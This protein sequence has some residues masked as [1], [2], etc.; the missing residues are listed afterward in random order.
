MKLLFG[1]AALAL[2]MVSCLKTEARAIRIGS[3]DF[4]ESVLIAEIITQFLNANGIAAEHRKGLGGT[5]VLWGALKNSDIDIYPEYSGTIDKEI[6]CHDQR[7]VQGESLESALARFG[8]AKSGR[9]GFNNS[10]GLGMVEA[11]AESL[12]IHKISDLARYPSLRLVFSSG[13]LNRDDGYKGLR[14]K[15]VLPQN[16]ARGIQHSYA[17]MGLLNDAID[18]TDVYTTDA[19]IAQYKLR[20]LRDDHAFFTRYDALLLY[21]SAMAQTHPHLL[22]LLN[23]F[24]GAFTN[25]E[26][27]Q[28]NAQVLSG[29][30]SDFV[31]A[32]RF[33]KNKFNVETEAQAQSAID[34]MLGHALEHLHMVIISLMMA[35]SMG[36]PLGLLV[37]RRRRVG[38]IILAIV[39]M[40]QT[41]PSLALLV[42]MMP[43]FGIGTWPAIVALFLY[44]LLPIV[45][46]TSN[47]LSGVSKELK[48]SAEVI[49]LTSST[50]LF[51]IEVPLASREILAGV[52]TAAIINIGTAVLGALIGAG[53]FGEPILTGIR[54]NDLS[55]TLQGA[56]P[57]AFMALL[58]QWGFDSLDRILVPRGL[59]LTIGAG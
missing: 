44:S 17:Y 56:L 2:L 7:Y 27:A 45:R 46:H 12:G 36:L 39:G 32:S 26:I 33:L 4:T 21:R 34:R 29:G 22:E 57:A 53:G 24:E 13:F 54:L 20:V 52:K 49:G 55:L 15:Y 41:I 10:Y 3:K 38:K 11:K 51:R 35:L 31:V 18:V 25:D 48:E 16:E 8:V 47:G 43:L 42:L 5:E 19:E 1:I 30:D 6:L 23:H 14:K 37:S 28:L 59:R 58:V 50:I 9:L 40:I